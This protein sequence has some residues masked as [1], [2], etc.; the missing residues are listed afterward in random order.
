[1]NKLQLI[2]TDLLPEYLSQVQNIAHQFDALKEAEI[3]TDTFS[4]YT[5]VASVFSSKIER[6][7]IELDSY[8]KHKALGI[9]FQPDYTK[10]QTI[11]T[12][13]ILLPKQMH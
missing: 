3:S 1:M 6:E 2:K 10:K 5:S 11:Y 9:E 4:F 7:E 13:H 12:R 8:I